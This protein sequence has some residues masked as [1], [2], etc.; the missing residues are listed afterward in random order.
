MSKRKTTGEYTKGTAHAPKTSKVVHAPH[1]PRPA[2]RKNERTGGL[3]GMT[4]GTGTEKKYLDTV[5]S[6]SAL[7]L[8][9]TPAVPL[10]INGVV[11]GVDANMRVGRKVQWESILT[12][13]TISLNGT[14]L[15]SAYR[16]MLVVDKQAN[17]AVCAASDILAT[18]DFTS[19]NNM[20]NRARFVTLWDKKGVVSTAGETIKI[21]ELFLRKK[22]Q[23]IFSGTTA[24]I[25]SITSGALYLLAFGNIT[26]ASGLVVAG[27]IRLRYT[28]DN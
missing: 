3:L 24:A 27:Y 15:S 9:T 12:R 7:N 2:P 25:G 23:T 19:A 11:Q 13:L 17:A 4:S 21:E 20:G 1:P 10:L 8:L 18:Q 14:P 5:V 26:V 16:L 22:F 28:D 6:I